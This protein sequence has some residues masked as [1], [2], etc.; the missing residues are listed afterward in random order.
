[1]AVNLSSSA[2]EIRERRL[3]AVLRFD[4]TASELHEKS[5]A[6]ALKMTDCSYSQCSDCQEFCAKTLL[7]FIQGAAVVCH[8]PIGCYS[9]QALNNNGGRA[10]AVQRGLSEFNCETIC[11]NIQERDTVYGGVEKLRNAC[12]EVYKRSKP[13][14]I[15]ITTSCASG[16]VGDDV[17]GVAEEI[18]AELSIPVVPISCEGFK[19]KIWTTGFDAAFH[20]IM[21]KI[22]K[23]A[24]KKQEDLVNIYNFQG[25][26]TFTALLA[27]LNLRCQF[28]IPMNTVPQIEKL[29][30]A[31]CSAHICE[32]LGTYV[33]AGFEDHFGVPEVKACPP[34]G[35]YWT[36]E[37]LREIARLT[38]RTDIVEDVIE[39]EH[40]RIEEPLA[41]LR[42]QL[43]GKTVYVIAGDSFT[44]NISNALHDLG[45]TIIGVNAL[46]H[47]QKT[48]SGSVDTL[49]SL[50]ENV[51]NIE[52]FCVC[53]KQPYQ[54][55]KRLRKL[56][57][58]FLLTRHEGLTILGYK[59]GIPSTFE[60]DAN[61]SAG[62]DGLLTLGKRL[63][64]NWQTR[65]FNKT[66]H[67]HSS[68]PYTDWWMNAEGVSL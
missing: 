13:S 38:N 29:S 9:M 21:K 23:P 33:V 31:A 42:K 7:C 24:Q 43:E 49:G 41:E 36:D 15:F 11:T 40:K 65:Q 59:L 30:E 14:A 64:E 58:D 26:D 37:W 28:V 18:E 45:L 68:F 53:N 8:S 46:H 39:S 27:K 12:F 48:D 10:C 34:Y 3:N 50:I 1:M 4:G 54:I 44:H 20:G 22:V 25:S 35:I 55:V 62:Y 63:L 60:G 5:K 32:T 19:S 51:G 57:P 66:I 67:E 2:P 17:E 61:I 47:D 52:S 6:S 56:R 16:I